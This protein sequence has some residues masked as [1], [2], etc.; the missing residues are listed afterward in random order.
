MW[1]VSAF[2]LYAYLSLEKTSLEPLY[3]FSVL[4]VSRKPAI[5]PGFILYSVTFGNVV[6]IFVPQ[7]Y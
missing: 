4:K 1:V 5:I 2:L 6:Y 7:I 3:D